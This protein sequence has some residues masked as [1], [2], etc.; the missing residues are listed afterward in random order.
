MELEEALK[1][2][3]SSIKEDRAQLLM[4]QILADNF[5]T[6]SFVGFYDKRPTD[7]NTIYI[8]QFVSESVF[9]CGE[10]SL[11][12]GQCGL[13]AS[14]LE[15]QIVQDV[16]ECENY[17]AC[18]T[19]TMSEIVLPCFGHSGELR[20]VFDIDSPIVGDFD[21]VDKFNLLKFIK[22]VYNH[23]NI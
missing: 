20:T 7:P 16:R 10:I 13:C 19:D 8:G 14:T 6:W 4:S 15:T 9:P 2:E 11:G 5:K 17:I 18:D 23:E 1:T 12:K 22:L 21:D 3:G